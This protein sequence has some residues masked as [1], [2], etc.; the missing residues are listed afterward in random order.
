MPKKIKTERYVWLD[1]TFTLLA[2]EV[3][4]YFYYGTRTLVTAGLCIA[5]SLAAE[6]IFLRF[7]GRK[8]TADDLTCTSDALIISLMLPASID[9]TIP[10]IACVFAVIAA[11]NIFGGRRNM[12]FSP[13]AAACVFMLTSWKREL[14]NYPA[15]H[16]KIPLSE[17]SPELSASASYIFNHTGIMNYTDFEILLGNFAG[18]VGAVSILLLLVAGVILI[19]RRDIS[20]GAFVGAVGGYS[21]MAYFCPVAA[22]GILSVKYALSTNMV[23]FAAIYI[24]SDLRI[25]PKRNYYAFFYGLF[26]AVSAYVITVTTGTENVI[27]IMSLIFT[28]V[29]LAFKNLQKRIDT[30]YALEAEAARLSEEES[31][32]ETVSAPQEAEP[33]E[34]AD[35]KASELTASDNEAESETEIASDEEVPAADE[36]LDA[37]EADDTP[38]EEEETAEG[39]DTDE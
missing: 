25:A 13:A 37:D 6:L 39:A 11:K 27:V 29:S 34:A 9:Y 23:L 4:A 5:V 16:E 20:W 10:A 19:F 38:S 3:M 2:L 1:L 24:I 15:P 21:F 35:D 17:A 22:N 12:I 7:T 18:P 8:F 33:E 14:L 36:T 30:E 26:I 32:M 31:V 28:P